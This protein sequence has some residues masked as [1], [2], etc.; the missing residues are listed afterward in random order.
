MSSRKICIRRELQFK[1]A[2]FDS[3]GKRLSIQLGQ[4]VATSEVFYI[5]CLEDEVSEVDRVLK[6]I[7]Q[8]PVL[9]SESLTNPYPISFKFGLERKFLPGMTDNR[10]R[11]LTEAFKVRDLKVGVSSGD[12]FWFQSLPAEKIR[13][14][15]VNKWIQESVVISSESP[16]S[17]FNP[18]N[19]EPV[20]AFSRAS[21][22]YVPLK[23]ASDSELTAISQRGLLA[24]SLV[25]MKEIQNYFRSE[26]RDP[27]D[28]ELEV[29]AQTWSEHCKHKIFA[30]TFHYEG[31]DSRIP[32]V[33]QGL[34]KNTI[35]GV[36]E[37]MDRPWL[38]SV[39]S[40]NAGVIQFSAQWG[41]AIKLETHN[42][43]S[44]LD[45]FG[46]AIT[47][48]VGVN[49]DILGTGIGA[50][51]LFNLNFFCVGPLTDDVALPEGILHP[52]EI[53]RG[54]VKGVEE[55]GNQ[56][57]IPTVGGGLV[58]DPSYLG[59]PLV[60]VGTGGK[61]PVKILHQSS[62]KKEILSGDHVVMVGG[63]VGRDGI[64]GAT[65]SSLEMT[66]GLPSSVV[67]LGDPITQKRMS[68]FLLKARDLGLYRTLTDNG[69]GGLSS[70]VGELSLMSGGA[71]LDLEKVPLKS[72]QLT[73]AE[74]LISESQERMTVAVP[75]GRWESFS[76]LAQTYGVEATVI[77]EFNQ[78]G[79]FEAYYAD[80]RALSL[81]L[82]F[83]HEGCPKLRVV[84]KDRSVPEEYKQSMWTTTESFSALSAVYENLERVL[85][86]PSI[87][88]KEPI[89]SQYDHEVKGLSVVKPQTKRFDKADGPASPCDAS[90]QRLDY[91]STIG[92]V[93]GLG[94]AR[95]WSKRDTY[96]M[97]AMAVDEAVRNAVCAGAEYRLDH[98]EPFA[99]VDNFCFADPLNSEERA[100]DLL[101]C[102]YGMR[103]AAVA[104]GLPFVSGKDSLKNSYRGKLNGAPHEIHVTPTLLITALAKISDI[105]TQ[106]RTSHFKSVG[107][108]VYRLGPEFTHWSRSVPNWDLA[109]KLYAWLGSAES[110]ALVSCHD[111]SEGGWLVAVWEACSF[112]GFWVEKAFND[113]TLLDPIQS[114]GEGFHQFVVSVAPENANAVE[115]EWQRLDIPFQHKGEV[116]KVPAHQTDFMSRCWSSFS[117]GLLCAKL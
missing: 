76:E 51:P 53:L 97:G 23:N 65:F 59:K 24:L 13:E 42:S 95:E 5:T 28:A 18:K 61:I 107:D 44:A 109:K 71:R 22:Q 4:P 114:F 87:C 78:S 80:E 36:T 83:L 3:R 90:V 115:A 39:F 104:L 74:I 94:M 25:E 58:V 102:A 41:V 34:F 60:F 85:A 21:I 35:R 16:G 108:Q 62:V 88:S 117:K 12:I 63:R 14:T 98:A 30:A 93:V 27:T 2:D 110:R 66:T 79:R 43:P 113:A 9:H 72:L 69:A 31:S 82:D 11:T 57:G 91:D 37:I 100:G 84:A 7:W 8:D 19:P 92:I 73:A 68:D 106:V 77:G 56:S 20:P 32:K 1:T 10:A 47:G 29:I 103:D 96:L 67:Q 86:D 105:A 50:E 33:T 46:G 89:F 111:V 26:N 55:G 54:L 45:P 101:R 112:G 64:H 116:Q 15:L 49:R 52:R 70:S 40:D 81:T 6:S 99:L 48:I 75:V 17:R 38:M